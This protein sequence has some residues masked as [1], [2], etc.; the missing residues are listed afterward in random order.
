MLAKISP[1]SPRGIIP[2]PIERQSRSAPSAPRPHAC[3]PS[4]AAAVSAAAKSRISGRTK[5][6]RSTRIPI[7]TKKTGTRNDEIGRTS[8]SSFFSPFAIRSR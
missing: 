6:L 5:A 3:L 2:I 8:S 1:T 7:N 4:I